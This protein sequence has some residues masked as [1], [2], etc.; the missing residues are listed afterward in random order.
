MHAV[1]LSIEGR[2][3]ENSRTQSE[4]NN[5]AATDCM[6]RGPSGWETNSALMLLFLVL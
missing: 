3:H 4:Q 6:Q 2:L 5:G 1:L